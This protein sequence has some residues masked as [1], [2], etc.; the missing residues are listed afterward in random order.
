MTKP[1]FG[2]CDQVRLKLA[3]SVTGTS[4]GLEILDIAS[5]DVILSH[6]PTTNVFAVRMWQK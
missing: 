6:Q 1:V 5:R 3:C 2:V 4:Q